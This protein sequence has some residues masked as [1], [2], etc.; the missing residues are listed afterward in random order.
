MRQ[1]GVCSELAEAN[2]GLPQR[3]PTPRRGAPRSVPHARYSCAGARA[4]AA[5]ALSAFPAPRQRDPSHGSG[6][7]AAQIATHPLEGAHPFGS[8][9]VLSIPA[10]PRGRCARYAPL[11]DTMLAQSLARG[12]G[13][14][15]RCRGGEI[16]AIQPHVATRRGTFG[17]GCEAML[18]GVASSASPWCLHHQGLGERSQSRP[19]EWARAA[20][21]SPGSWG[22]QRWK[23]EEEWW[24]CLLRGASAPRERGVRRAHAARRPEVDEPR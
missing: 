1:T 15:P 5:D 17:K 3:D 13:C 21:I 8:I 4:E 16:S 19:R 7:P 22:G 24:R 9:A 2:A 12:G 11:R 10:L 20:A 23:A 18:L 14:P 6:I